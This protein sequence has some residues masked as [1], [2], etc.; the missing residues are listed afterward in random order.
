MIFAEASIPSLSI[1]LVSMKVV[2][3]SAYRLNDPLGG[4]PHIV[5]EDGRQSDGY[6]SV[7]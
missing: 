5:H 1:G 3:R 7:Y 2:A 4:L 6:I